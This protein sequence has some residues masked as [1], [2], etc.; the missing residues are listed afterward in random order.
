MKKNIEFK[1]SVFGYLSGEARQTEQYQTLKVQIENNGF[2]TINGAKVYNTE[3]SLVLVSEKIPAVNMLVPKG[4]NRNTEFSGVEFID[5][6]V[7][8][9]NEGREYF[10]KAYP[11]PDSGIYSSFGEVYAKEIYRN[12]QSIQC[13]DKGWRYVIDYAPGII[14]NSIIK[15]YGYYAG[16]VSKIE[17][18]VDVYPLFFE[19]MEKEQ[20]SDKTKV[21]SFGSKNRVVH[22]LSINQIALKYVY[23]GLQITRKNGNDIV[24]EYGHNSGE[25]LFQRFTFYSSVAN[26]KAKPDL[27]TPK[28]LENKIN[29]IESVIELLPTDKQARAKDEV[30]ILKTIYENEYQ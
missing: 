2:F 9:Y 16:I 15:E 21:I 12:F 27:C 26:R 18:L 29:L 10:K 28:K 11:I 17:E 20:I 3:L 8:A 19:E 22:K 30:L 25:R 24:K 23:E 5:L 4:S 14:S 1:Y 7:S 6:Y 13:D